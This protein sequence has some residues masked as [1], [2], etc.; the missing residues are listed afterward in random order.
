M[1]KPSE[2]RTKDGV[3]RKGKGSLIV[4]R[5]PTTFDKCVGTA[6]I[7]DLF[8]DSVTSSSKTTT[9]TYKNVHVDTVDLISFSS[10]GPANREDFAVAA[11]T[12]YTKPQVRVRLFIKNRFEIY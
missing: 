6:E 10:G 3:P 4:N 12:V 5:K 11:N 7:T 8:T 2:N 1:P 9:K